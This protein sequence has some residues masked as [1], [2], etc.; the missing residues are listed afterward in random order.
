MGGFGGGLFVTSDNM[1]GTLTITDSTI[2]GNTG[3]SWTSVGSGT[4]TNVGT[5]IGVNAKSISVT[6][7][8]VQGM[9]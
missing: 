4:V 8:T 3:G 6:S 5:A 1:Q 2:T 9:P 7:S